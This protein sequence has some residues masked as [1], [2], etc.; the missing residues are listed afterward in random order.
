[1]NIESI[2]DDF[3]EAI[4]GGDKSPA[5]S[6]IIGD[7]KLTAEQ[8]IGIYSGSVHGI[9][10]QALGTTF[11]VC[12]A[13]LGDEFFANMCE[14]FINQHPPCSSFFADYGNKLPQFINTFEHVRDIPYLADITQLEWTRNQVWH[15][16]Y[17]QSAD[18]STLA[19]ITEKQQAGLVF[20]LSKTLRLI[21]SPYRIDHIWF[22]HQEGSE[23]R[24]ED[25]NLNKTVKLF[26]WKDKDRLK[27]SLMNHTQEDNI[28]WD[29]IDAIS[30]GKTLEELAERFVE[31]L[32][33]LL[34]QAIQSGWIES[35]TTK[36]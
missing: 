34:N 24:L 16:H 5:T 25:I 22:A 30:T 23:I 35:F 31:A 26:I 12:K 3:V 29:F 19:E 14:I 32:P 9:L 33:T 28:F 11:P 36:K 18:F 2:Q 8:R 10:T 13:L 27:I 1:V 17:Q 7:N 4:F 15:A 20:T 6:H 21:Q